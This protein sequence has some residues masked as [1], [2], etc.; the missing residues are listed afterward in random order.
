M[1]TRQGVKGMNI[2]VCEDNPSDREAICGCISDY[3]ARNCYVNHIH[4]F[5][6][7]EALLSA[8]APGVFDILF[9][10]IYL[11][12]ISGMEAARKIR[13]TDPNCA[14]VIVTVSRAHALES[15]AVQAVA[16]VEKTITQEKVDKALFMCRHEFEKNSRFIQI[17]ADRG[18]YIDIPLA[19]VQYIEVYDKESVLHLGGSTP[20][21]R[22]PLD[23]IEQR[24]GGG[25]FLRCH[26]CYIVNMNYVE[27]MLEHDFLMK[28][29]E[30]VPIRK[31]GR[32]EIRIA[33]A[34]FM[35]CGAFKGGPL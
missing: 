21:T 25:P 35:T 7:A 6:S 20:K 5:E 4:V 24:L 33:F 22:L 30:R 2:A 11:G 34:R 16:Y 32:A 18:N 26:R 23:E 19:N 27:D 14:L 17:S 28:N 15:Y 9:L 8:F 13:K 1:T 29:G 10:D 12:G 3:C 31:N